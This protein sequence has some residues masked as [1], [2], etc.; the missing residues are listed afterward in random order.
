M[1]MIL[2]GDDP[3][4]RE[5]TGIGSI[6]RTTSLPLAYLGTHRLDGPRNARLRLRKVYLLLWCVCE[7]NWSSSLPDQKMAATLIVSTI[8][9]VLILSVLAV[10]SRYKGI[11]W[12]NVSLGQISP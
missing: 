4:W 3:V 6:S 5:T 9:C 11:P 1:V 12:K 8:I 2:R 7:R 10:R